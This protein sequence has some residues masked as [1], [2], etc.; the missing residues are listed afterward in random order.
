MMGDKYA[1]VFVLGK[2]FLFYSNVCEEAA[3][4]ILA[5]ATLNIRLAG[6]KRARK[7]TLACFV[8]SSVTKK[9]LVL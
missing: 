1:G 3:R 4:C 5:Y 2:F 7:N 8:Q 9:K 6:K